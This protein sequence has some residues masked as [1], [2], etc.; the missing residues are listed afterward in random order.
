MIRS[1]A[2][3]PLQQAVPGALAALL[4]DAPLSPGKVAFV[5]RAAVGASLDRV[6]TAR[7]DDR[8][9]IVDASSAHWA[10]EV[11]RSRDLILDRLQALLGSDVVNRISVREPPDAPQR[12][13]RHR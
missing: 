7:L 5:W 3:R 12:R 13:R 11:V 10:R 4:R 9:L 6:T 2:V 1:N 8:V